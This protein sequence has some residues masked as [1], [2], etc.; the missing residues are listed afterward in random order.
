MEIQV[1]QREVYGNILYYPIC[2]KA[3]AFARL[4]E[5]K[6]LTSYAIEEIKGLGYK[7]IVNIF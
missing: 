6:T 3:K 5:K 1:K 7:V 2:E 4:T